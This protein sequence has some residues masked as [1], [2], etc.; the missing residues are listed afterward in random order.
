MKDIVCK[1]MDK[2][3]ILGYREEV[4]VNGR[5]GLFLPVSFQCVDDGKRVMAFYDI[6]GTDELKTQYDG[7]EA[8]FIA[9][10]ILRGMLDA[11]E[12]YLMPQDYL[13]KRELVRVGRRGEIKLIYYPE[14]INKHSSRD[15]GNLV[16]R[17]K[18]KVFLKELFPKDGIAYRSVLDNTISTLSDGTLGMETCIRKL[19]MTKEDSF[20]IKRDRSWSGIDLSLQMV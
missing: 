5:V 3:T 10:K 11:A 15:I 18:V 4:L 14:S 12:Y 8:P 7:S 2:N 17:N 20:I 6:S 19:E 13:L 1:E 9:T 16:F